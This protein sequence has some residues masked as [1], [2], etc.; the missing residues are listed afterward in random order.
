[1]IYRILRFI[2]RLSLNA[3][4]R[5]Q[6]IVGQNKVPQE[7]ALIFVANHPSA[8]M[9]PLAVGLAVHRELHFIAA[10]EYVGKGLKGK[11]FQNQ[12][13]MI[14]VFRP[15]TMPG[16]THKNKEMFEQCYAH[17]GQEKSLLIFP[18]GNS[19]TERRLRSLKTGVA[20]MA[21]GASKAHPEMP[22]VRIVPV[23]LNYS[24][25]HQFRSDLYVQIGDPIDIEDYLKMEDER[26]AVRELTEEVAHEL[27][28]TL[29]H[30]EKEHHDDFLEQV[31]DIYQP[32]LQ[33]LLELEKDDLQGNHDLQK[34]IIA[35]LDH[36]DQ[37]SPEEI[38]QFK[39]K[40]GTYNQGL[41]KLGISE[42]SMKEL[43]IG[44]PP[45]SALLLLLLAPVYLV[46]FL[47]NALP[48]F[49]ARAIVIGLRIRDSF[50][51]SLAMSIGALCFL[52]WYIG[53]AIFLGL[54]TPLGYWSISFPFV[55]YF[56]GLISLKIGGLVSRFLLRRKLRIQLQE[57]KKEVLQMIQ[58]REEIL[59]EL[60]DF[61]LRFIASEPL[62]SA[63]TK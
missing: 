48:Y 37:E 52:L 2:F 16:E 57:Q 53:G 9:D 54:K 60:E 24:D 49:L 31:E 40:V 6:H 18:E 63:A 21:I 27:R 36:F 34:N 3:Y 38:E 58:M 42:I 45:Y 1:M 33:D 35:A 55:C 7:G 8:F 15:N 19:I 10:G 5:R 17:L 44:N 13:H 62:S 56:F 22:P 23:G 61:R 59:D 41:K 50:L 28:S 46:G 26:E 43:R 20:R 32:E 39:S 4:F 51:G 30:I 47:L 11:F 29:L 12:L 25:P 14:P